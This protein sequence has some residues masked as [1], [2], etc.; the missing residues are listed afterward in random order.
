MVQVDS[1]LNPSKPAV[2]AP[3]T[4]FSRYSVPVLVVERSRVVGVLPLRRLY[5][6][7]IVH[8][9]GSDSQKQKPQPNGQKRPA[10]IE[11]LL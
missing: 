3:E 4:M 2:G 1:E 6:I 7:H 8:K 9:T 10:C 11:Q 5:T